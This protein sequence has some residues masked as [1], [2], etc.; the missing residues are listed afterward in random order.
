VVNPGALKNQIE[1]GII[2]SISRAL[3]EEVTFD[4]SRITSLDW[5]S[6]PIITFNEIPAEVDIVLL[7]RPDLPPMRAGEPASETVWPGI[8]NAIYDAIGVRLRQLPF[9]PPRVLAGLGL[10]S[11][12]S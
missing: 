8:A 7:D 2:Q 10:V 3:K 1:G 5:K 11:A 12:K 4:R 6:Y 9:T